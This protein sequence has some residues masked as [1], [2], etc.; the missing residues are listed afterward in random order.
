MDEHSNEDETELVEVVRQK[1]GP[2][3]YATTIAYGILI[4]AILLGFW[5]VQEVSQQVA[6]E[7]ERRAYILCE[8]NNEDRITIVELLEDL[9][10][11]NEAVIEDLD[12][13]VQEYLNEVR[14]AREEFMAQAAIDLAPTECPPNPDEIE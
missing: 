2:R 4:A 7:T 1:R 14:P 9:T 12:P 11:I 13:V 8:T 3:S 5:R 10:F 6:L